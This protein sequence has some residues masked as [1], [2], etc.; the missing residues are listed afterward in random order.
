MRETNGNNCT[1]HL[2]T[3]L[4]QDFDEEYYLDHLAVL[5]NKITRMA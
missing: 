2:A 5:I 1:I 3:K 4:G